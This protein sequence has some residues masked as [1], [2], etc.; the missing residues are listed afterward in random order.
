M[1]F[2]IRYILPG[3]LILS[4][5]LLFWIYTNLL[6]VSVEIFKYMIVEISYTRTDKILSALDFNSKS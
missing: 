6:T 3:D 4:I 2:R 1:F 5:I